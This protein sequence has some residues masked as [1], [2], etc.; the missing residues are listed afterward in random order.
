MDDV[1]PCE[2]ASVLPAYLRPAVPYE[3]FNK[4]QVECLEAWNSDSNLLVSAPTGSGKTMCFELALLRR[5]HVALESSEAKHL[6]PS[7]LNGKVV[8]VAPTKALCTERGDDWKR[9]YAYTGLRVEIIT[10]DVNV[11][12]SDSTLLNADLVITTAEKWDSLTR[13]IGSHTTSDIMSQICLLLLDEVHQLGDSRGAIMESV[14]TRMLATSDEVKRNASSVTGATPI[15]SLRVIAVSATVKNVKDVGIW[16]RVDPD[17]VKE[18]DQSYRPVELEYKLLGYHIRNPWQAS[19]VYD[20]RTL[21]VLRNFGDGKPALVF[22]PSRRQTSLSAN[23]L[24]ERLNRDSPDAATQGNTLT[25]HLSLEQRHRLR[26]YAAKCSDRALATLLPSG[27]AMHNAEIS[28]ENRNLVE[29]LFRD[30]L[31]LCLFSTSTLAQGVNLP[32]RLVVIAGTTVYRNGALQEYDRNLLLQMSG[33]AG[34][35]GLDTKGVVAIMTSKSSVRRYDNIQKAV[36]ANIESQLES[37]LE[38]CI[39]AEIARQFITDVPSAVFFLTNTFFWI[40]E[41]KRHRSEFQNDENKLRALITSTAVA[42]VNKLAN[43]HLVRFD[44][45]YFGVSSTSAGLTMAKYCLSFETLQLL[46]T[47]IPKVSSPAQVLR[48]ISASAEVLDGLCI[49]RA[50]KKRLNEMNEFI[51]LPVRG[52]VKEPVDKAVILLQMILGDNIETNTIDFALRSEALRLMQSVSRVCSC[53]TSLILDLSLKVPYEAM[54]SVLQV[55]RGL[56]NHCYWDGP[57]VL[58]QIPGISPAKTKALA[59]HGISTIGALARAD[60]G[61]IDDLLCVK[62]PFGKRLLERLKE[63]PKFHVQTVVR[64]HPEPGGQISQIEVHITV[65]AQIGHRKPRQRKGERGFVLVGSHSRGFIDAKTF[66]LEEVS[67]H[68]VFHVPPDGSPRRG[69]WIDVIVGSDSIIGIDECARFPQEEGNEGLTQSQVIPSQ[70]PMSKAVKELRAS[71]QASKLLVTHGRVSKR[72]VQT[73]V[74]QALGQSNTHAMTTAFV[75]GRVNKREANPGTLLSQQNSAVKRPEDV[76]ITS[77]DTSPEISPGPPSP[78]T[79][80]PIDDLTEPHKSIETVPDKFLLERHRNSGRHRRFEPLFAAGSTRPNLKRASGPLASG[81]AK[82]LERG[83]TAS[84]SGSTV[85]QSGQAGRE[86]DGMLRSLF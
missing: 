21:E 85:L 56:T 29:R 64:R 63:F 18:F 19:K 5:L 31:V 80:E 66:R 79:C 33:R 58:R 2:V 11:S 78:A 45:D 13:N 54:F 68:F 81:A 40:R 69:K 73:T 74:S 57:T 25:R 34:R 76:F 22:C 15:A 38:E 1:L 3:N 44:D 67:Q 14:V 84:V 28:P 41:K 77:P 16:L 17:H 48:I 62:A 27:V 83:N 24:V 30:S 7:G 49:R 32:A 12:T 51:R 60:F 50:E 20:S 55:C 70:N 59:K 52:R 6:G 43:T 72:F 46:M 8:F 53:L 65:S 10:G 75:R 26:S 23:A 82:D 42:V 61:V 9:R 86:Y 35:L 39:N 47:E 36:P 71:G 37:R 4:L